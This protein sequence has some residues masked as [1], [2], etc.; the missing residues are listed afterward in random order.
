MTISQKIQ[1]QFPILNRKVNGKR[2]AYLDNASTTQKPICIID[3]LTNYYKNYNANI[4]R[5]IHKLS[6]EA[7]IAYEDTRKETAKFINAKSEK[8]IVF[9][10]NATESINL[11]AYTWGEQNIKEKNEILVSALEHHSNLIP[12]QQLAKRKN[13]L[14]LT[15]PLKNDYTLDMEAF[16][17]MMSKNVKLVCVSGMSNVLGTIPP[18]KEII[19]K[20]HQVEALV[21]IDG[22]Q[23]V[24]HQP[25]D[26][27][28]LD[29]DF[30][31]FSSHKML[32]P[33]G[34]G[35][36]YGK[37]DILEK[38]PPF[39]FGG[40]MAQSVKNCEA[41][42]SE[43]P[44]KFEAGTPNIAD[45]IAFKEA[46]KFIEKIGLKNIQKHDAELLKYAREKFS[47]YPQV[48]LYGPQNSGPVLS[49]TIKGIH[50]HD[51]AT[52]FDEEGVAIRAGHHCAQPVIEKLHVPATARMSF[53]FYNTRED[54]DQAEKALKK[55][56]W[57]FI[58]K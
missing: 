42:F 50:A 34:V 49:F 25:T 2:L 54:I 13:A 38:M 32:G 11:V 16:D 23:S 10:R 51:I 55:V 46:L 6:E 3:A 37:E 7:T 36:L 57:T 22:A 8:E 40:E 56:I 17:Q 24:A 28:D 15:I 33:T 21:L 9:T 35:I 4:H 44:W 29:C 5:G 39:L 45:V 43:I 58:Q 52:I 53:Y 1:S 31:V 48:T 30:F 41:S 19:K 47:K 12:W 26:V 14:L 18:L 20:A 27:Q